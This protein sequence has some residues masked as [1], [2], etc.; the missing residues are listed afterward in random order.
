[1]LLEGKVSKVRKERPSGEHKMRL[2]DAARP[3]TNH[4]VCANKERDLFIEAQ[5]PLLEK[6]GEWAS[7]GTLPFQLVSNGPEKITAQRHLD[8]PGSL[9]SAPPPPPRMYNE[10]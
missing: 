10:Y 4:P 5:P 6:G 7:L 1:L 8:T 2:R 9:S 3:F